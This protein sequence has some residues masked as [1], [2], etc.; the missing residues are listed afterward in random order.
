MYQNTI[1]RENTHQYFAFSAAATALSNTP[2]VG[3]PYITY[4]N[5]QWIS[6]KNRCDVNSHDERCAV[7]K[8]TSSRVFKPQTKTIRIVFRRSLSGR[9]LTKRGCHTYSGDDSSGMI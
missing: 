4:A 5:H 3:F 1:S 2:L 9:R 6:I 8:R 7:V